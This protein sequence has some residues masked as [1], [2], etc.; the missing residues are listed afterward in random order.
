LYRKS[1]HTFYDQYFFFNLAFVEIIW[2]T[3]QSRTG[4]RWYHYMVHALCML[5]NEGY[6]HTLRICN[7]DCFYTSTI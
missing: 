7:N 3:P 5:G 2:K 1:K 6:K 4:H